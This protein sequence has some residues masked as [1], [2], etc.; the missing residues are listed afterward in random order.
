VLE[1]DVAPA[2]RERLGHA[3]ARVR[4]CRRNRPVLV[5]ELREEPV[6][7]R[8]VEV[9]GFRLP[10]PGRPV[11]AFEEPDAFSLRS[12]S[13]IVRRCAAVTSAA[14]VERPRMRS[15]CASR[16][17]RYRSRVEG[18]IGEARLAVQSANPSRSSPRVVLGE[19]TRLTVFSTLTETRR[20]SAIA[21]VTVVASRERRTAFPPTLRR[22]S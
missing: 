17:V 6:D 20:A 18:A 8:A 9:A 5:A 2:E 7:L 10:L 22:S 4:E 14:R 13:I 16:R 11:A 3:E 21:S 1:V 15:A 19:P 12:R